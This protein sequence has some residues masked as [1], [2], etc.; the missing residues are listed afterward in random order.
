MGQNGNGALKDAERRGAPGCGGG[1]GRMRRSGGE[2]EGPRRGEPAAPDGARR[3][4]TAANV[5][6]CLSHS[7]N[8]A[9][10]QRSEAH[11]PEFL[12]RPPLIR[13]KP[14]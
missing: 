3:R 6:T 5:A 8:Y 1:G 2:G 9:T 4:P 11:F 10:Q 12:G 13:L 7:S 14:R